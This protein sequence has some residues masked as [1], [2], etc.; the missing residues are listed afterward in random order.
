MPTKTQTQDQERTLAWNAINYMREVASDLLGDWP[1][2][3]PDTTN[4][5][6]RPTAWLMRCETRQQELAAHM[7]HF[8]YQVAYHAPGWIRVT[9]RPTNYEAV[10]DKE[11]RRAQ[12][13]VDW[14]RETATDEDLHHFTNAL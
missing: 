7:A 11:I 13:R 8:G 14:L 3:E 9:G 12:Q 10:R 2:G 6:E 1:A 4:G 5:Q